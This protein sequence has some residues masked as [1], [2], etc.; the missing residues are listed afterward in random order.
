LEGERP[1]GLRG[2]MIDIT[3]RKQTEIQL[4]KLSLAVEQSPAAVLITNLDAAIEYVNPK[5]TQIT[6]YSFDEVRGQNPRMLQSGNLAA[7]DYRKLWQTLLAGEEWHGEFHNRRKDGSL[8][9]EHA[10][11]SPLRNDQGRVTH[12]VAVKED[13]TTQKQYEQQ[14]EYKATHDELTGLANRALF[15]NLLEQSIHYAHRS[16]RMVAE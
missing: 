6:G 1:V 15:K 7:E 3:E 10:S 13:I 8:F 9:W 2:F 16:E 12:Y 14:L 5:F 4:Q 11:I